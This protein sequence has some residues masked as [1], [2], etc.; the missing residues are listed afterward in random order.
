M[1]AIAS[2]W[3]LVVFI[4]VTVTGVVY[5]YRKLGQEHIT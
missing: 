5:A 3:P 1:L 4:V 2:Y